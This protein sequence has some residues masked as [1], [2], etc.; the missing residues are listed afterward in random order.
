[1]E[2]KMKEATDNFPQLLDFVAR[3]P[4]VQKAQQILQEN[5]EV[6]VY[7]LYEGQRMLVSAAL[8]KESAQK[9]LLVL[10][11][12]EKRA[13]ELWED[14][15]QLLSGYEILYF[16]ALEMIP[17]EVIAQS[18][19]LEQ[20]RVE[21][22]SRLLLEKEKTFVVITTMEGIS[23]KLLHV[24]DFLQGML[25]LHVGMILEQQ[26]L[27]EHLVQY[28]Y[29]HVTQVEQP[30]QFSVRGGIFDIFVPY[31]KDPLRL[32]FFDDEIDSIRFFS[33][34]SQCSIEKIQSAWVVPGKEFFLLPSA[35]ETGISAI[36]EQFAL[37]VEQLS[38]KK[39]REP[40][41]RL[42]GKIGEVLE[43]LQQNV[44]FTGL[45]QY[46]TFFYSE[47]A[48]ILEYM[49]DKPLLLLDEAN[50]IQEAQE[51]LE[52]ERRQS[53]G[54]LLLRGGVLP[55]QAEYF[56]TLEELASMVQQTEH[57]CFSLLPKKSMFQQNEYRMALDCQ[58]IASFF[59]NPQM[60]VDELQNWMQQNYSI[61]ILL[62]SESK[63][64]RLQNLLADYDILCSWIAD[65]YQ[66]EP[67]KIYLAYGNISHG[68]R[69]PQSRLVILSETEVFQQQKKR[70]N[71]KFFQEDGKKI[72][73]LD[74]LKIGDYVVHL[75]HGIGRYMGVERLKVQDIE[76][77]YLI[78]KYADDGK[79]YIPVEQFDL[80][81]KYAVEEGA[82]P[83]VNKLGGSEWQ[84][85]KNKV[86][87]S[88][89]QLAEGLLA[90][91]A[92]RKSQEGY[93][94]SPDDQWQKEFED[95][96]PY[97]ET[98]DQLRAIEDVKR[99]MMSRTVMDRLIC[100]DVGYGKTEVAIRAAF[101]AV[102][103]GKQVAVLVPT[104]VLAQQ[105]Y[106]TFL[107]R[108]SPYGIRVDMLSRFVTAK[109]QKETKE[110]LQ[111]GSVDIVIGTHKLLSKTISFHDL[112]L[113]IIDEEQRFGVTHKEKI[114][115]MRSL[116]DVLTLS[117]TPIP[118]TLH[119][120]L[121]GI[122]D[123]SVIETPPQD[124]Y[125]IQTYIVERTP[126]LMK[127]AIRRELGRGGQV[128][129]VHNRV[130]DIA[131]LAE[132]IGLLVPE[133]RI[134]VGHGQMKEQELEQIMMDFIAH[135]ADVL[136]CTT[137][138]ETGLD[139][140]NANTMIVDEADKMGLS[141]LYQLRGRVGRSNRI[142]YAYLTYKK[143]K[144]L[145][146]LAEKRLA[147]IRE[148]TELGSGFKIAM[149]DLEIRGAGNLL[150]AEQHGHVAAV[151]F[152]LYCTMLD[153]AIRELKGEKSGH[154][155]EIEIDLQVSA[156][157]PE[158]YIRDSAV[159]LGFYQ[160]IQQAKSISRIHLLEDE[161]IDRFGDIPEETWNLLR[162]AELKT[163]CVA[164][165]IRSLKQNGGIVSLRFEP[166]TGMDMV[167]L[168]HLTQKYKKQL[169][170]RSDGGELVVRIAVGT[171]SAEKCL[172]LVKAI[173]LDMVT[174]VQKD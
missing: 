3:D 65:R 25:Q 171:L 41:E 79:L 7:G 167:K 112:G 90:I 144:S 20:K 101:K 128:Y 40:L 174:I 73:Q 47:Q 141:Q 42:Q 74:D 135:K 28:G 35:K 26:V 104:T 36:R 11:D 6:S 16:P 23:K 109:Q 103:D 145:S 60:M 19:T 50:R 78:I 66:A 57:I 152:D 154:R 150:G 172:D 156:Y 94:F 56:W 118:R 136:V 165:G 29:Q 87:A 2:A 114:K 17:Y 116:V 30:G 31:Y 49:G 69:F 46:Q 168:L 32:E 44:T 151:G 147:A 110:G 92:Q 170:Y 132:E 13:K 138:I 161:M 72:A 10:C 102:N 129:V 63:A 45:E 123:M 55:G 134:L 76:R 34:D 84:R 95:A 122:R 146:Q 137:I 158:Y 91:N 61:L 117:A 88:V 139:I 33:T 83:K 107:E 24:G 27:K 99:D 82:A 39:H 106:N 71:K 148:Y 89:E 113:L 155:R 62:T 54:E 115:E 37:Q 75:N 149:R 163:Y 119:M 85:T 157:I 120:S 111:S 162:I 52:K 124:R 131:R 159:K 127:D 59:G 1:M 53:F 38:K 77:D 86:K 4:E 121:V 18:G 67:G 58:T 51:Y 48:N 8:A 126:E 98:E 80:L 93:A 21:V 68:A 133:A 173:L 81:Q 43:R 22:L 169:H 143:D 64:L 142:A 160:R 130:D 105:H 97:V 166:D 164:V 125:P 9:N 15:V 14:F 100:G 153:E 12:T 108:F 96:F 70:V 140:A 5:K